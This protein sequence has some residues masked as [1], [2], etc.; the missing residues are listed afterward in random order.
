MVEFPQI[1]ILGKPA[2]LY[3]FPIAY[4]NIK[5]LGIEASY[6]SM[7]ANIGNEFDYRFDKHFLPF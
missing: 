5:G 3:I 7:Q 1:P 4:L 6:A 2:I